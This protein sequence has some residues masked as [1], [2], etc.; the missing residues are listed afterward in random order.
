MSRHTPRPSPSAD[1]KPRF[2][3]GFGRF[4]RAGAR[5]ASFL[6]G[7]VATAFWVPCSG[8]LVTE[9]ITFE[10]EPNS[11]PV[12]LTRS[13]QPEI[14]TNVWIDNSTQSE[15][16][17][18]VQVRDE[19]VDQPLEARW[20]I[21]TQDQM[22]PPFVS[23]PILGGT[24]PVRE[25]DI[26]VDTAG[27]QLYE[28][29]RFELVVSGSFIPDRVEPPFFRIVLDEDD[30]AYASWEIWEGEGEILT[31]PESRLKIFDSCTAFEPLLSNE[32]PLGPGA[33]GAG[34]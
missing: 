19:N 25:L 15:W 1:E 17:L 23:R 18:R 6:L 10:E 27:L 14:G 9:E 3:R 26:F 24:E 7:T 33:A 16:Q 28:C 13:G 2:F 31:P 11:P 34:P 4:S 32:T 8:C 29:H 12:I 30:L 20:R 5:L 21:Q 22:Q